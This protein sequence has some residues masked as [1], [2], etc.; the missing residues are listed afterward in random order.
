MGERR[1]T[2][3]LLALGIAVAASLAAGCGS[4]A[5]VS[6]DQIIKS[7]SLVRSELNPGYDIGADPFCEVDLDLLGSEDEVNAAKDGREGDLVVTSSS[8]SVG[9]KAV[10]PFDRS[11]AKKARRGLDSIQE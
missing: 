6:D 4:S 3:T 8:G 2:A 5:S 1:R 11:C 7:L 9:V 10:P